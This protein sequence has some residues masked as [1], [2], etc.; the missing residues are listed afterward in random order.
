MNWLQFFKS[1]KKKI[2]TIIGLAIAFLLW[3]VPISSLSDSSPSFSFEKCEISGGRL[4]T[5][6]DQQYFTDN[7]PDKMYLDELKRKFLA[8]GFSDQYWDSHFR[9]IWANYKENYDRD[10][11]NAVFYYKT[12]SWIDDLYTNWG[13]VKPFCDG[14]F[15]KCSLCRRYMTEIHGWINLGQ[16]SQGVEIDYRQ[17]GNK[18]M[19]YSLG[20]VIWHGDA[21]INPNTTVLIPENNRILSAWEAGLLAKQCVP[22]SMNLYNVDMTQVQPIYSV[23][24][25]DLSTLFDGMVHMYAQVNLLTGKVTCQQS[26]SIVY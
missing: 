21:M 1:N 16:N 15:S 24:G 3:I 18:T 6:N 12:D 2:I 20:S 8:L 9:L 14:S 17:H 7:E 4:A 22:F 19:V 23:S 11:I 13:D 26:A 25:E 10:E 5:W